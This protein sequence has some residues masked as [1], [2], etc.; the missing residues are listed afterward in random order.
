MDFSVYNED[1]PCFENSNICFVSVQRH[2]KDNL[3]TKKQPHQF[4]IKH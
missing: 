2:L 4:V 1:S 3:K